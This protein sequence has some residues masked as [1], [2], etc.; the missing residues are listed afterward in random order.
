MEQAVILS[1]F[2]GVCMCSFNLMHK[3]VEKR[4]KRSIFTHEFA[5][6]KLM[7]EIK[8]AFREDFLKMLP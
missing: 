7:E 5:S 8:E 3:E 4:L 1:A 6:D 2:T